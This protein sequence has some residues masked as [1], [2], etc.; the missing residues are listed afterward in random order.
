MDSPSVIAPLDCAC[1]I[2]GNAYSWQ[3]VDTLYSMLTRHLSRPVILHVYTE[4]DRAVPSHMVKHVLTPWSVHKLWWYKLQLFN[5][6]H[7]S[8]PVLY[9]DLDVVIVDNIDWIWQLPPDRFWAARDFKYL[10]R[11]S[12]TG[13][14]TSVMWWDTQKYHTVWENFKLLQLDLVVGQYPGDQ[15]Y[16]TA[17]I[18]KHNQATLDH[19]RV[20]SWKWQAL[21]GGY[22]PVARQHYRPGTGTHFGPDVSVLVCHGQ[23]KPHNISDPVIVHH[24][25]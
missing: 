2:V 7:H 21:D 23:P 9:F 1:V 19:G 25:K 5:A 20:T 22:D 17:A 3:Y 12:W 6:E 10:W 15:D 13:L 4:A 18:P 24:W 8:G 11:P 14:N 16:I